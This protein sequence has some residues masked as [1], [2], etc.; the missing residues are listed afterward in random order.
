MLKQV[1]KNNPVAWE[2]YLKAI[3]I[4][5][6]IFVILFRYFK[7]YSSRPIRRWD[8]VHG[9]VYAVTIGLIL[10][11]ALNFIY[12]QENFLYSRVYVGLSWALILV[13]FNTFRFVINKAERRY[14][15]AKALETRVIIL[16]IN[17]V[18]RHLIHWFKEAKYSG[19][20]VQ[21]IYSIGEG[22]KGGHIEN[23]EIL[24]S[25]EDFERHILLKNYLLIEEFW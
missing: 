4:A 10:F 13:Y 19:Y 16:G 22:E 21:G 11:M 8:V 12:R 24:G 5:L 18:A 3:F 15:K 9:S 14:I 1:F 6:P 20:C 23:C 7:L 2:N 17:K 25:I